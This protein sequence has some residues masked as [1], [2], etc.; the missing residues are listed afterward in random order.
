MLTDQEGR[1]RRNNIRIF[2]LQ[3]GAEGSSVTQLIEQLL[4]NELPLPTN[5]DLEL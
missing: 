1:S 2:G 5:V 3:E 4:K